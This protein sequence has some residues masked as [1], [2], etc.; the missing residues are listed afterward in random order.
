M[1][2]FQIQKKKTLRRL[3]FDIRYHQLEFIILGHFFVQIR[4]FEVQNSKETML[5]LSEIQI[6][7]RLTSIIVLCKTVSSEVAFLLSL[8]SNKSNNLVFKNSII[9]GNK[10]LVAAYILISSTRFC[11]WHK[12]NLLVENSS[13]EKFLAKVLAKISN[14]AA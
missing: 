3:N 2:R 6:F 14:L 7:R 13:D 9:C 12:K 8:R 4:S 1:G 5:L 11:L 10:I